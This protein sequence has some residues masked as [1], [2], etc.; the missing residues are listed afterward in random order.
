[1][2][3]FKTERSFGKLENLEKSHWIRLKL[4]IS[5]VF[6]GVWTGLSKP[7]FVRENLRAYYVNMNLK[8]INQSARTYNLVYFVIIV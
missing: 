6:F 3:D 5:N 2:G 4:K 7:K 8:P 1:M